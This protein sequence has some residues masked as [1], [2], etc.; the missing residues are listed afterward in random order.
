MQNNV[1]YLIIYITITISCSLQPVQQE[2]Y[3]V[4]QKAY[5]YTELQISLP[6]AKVPWEKINETIKQQPGFLSKTWLAGVGND[7]VGGFYAFDSIENARKFAREIFPQEANAVN[8]AFTTRVFDADVTEQ[9]SRAMGSP[10]F[11]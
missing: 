6:F 11:S 8:A 9:A 3:P 10:Y 5:V 2:E 4:S 1:R 7:S